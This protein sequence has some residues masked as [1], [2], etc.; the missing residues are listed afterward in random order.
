MTRTE[1]TPIRAPR[2]GPLTSTPTNVITADQRSENRPPLIF[3]STGGFFIYFFFKWCAVEDGNGQKEAQKSCAIV[4]STWKIRTDRESVKVKWLFFDQQLPNSFLFL[5]GVC[6]IYLGSKPDKAD[7]CS[8]SCQKV[9][10]VG[11]F[12]LI[13]VRGLGFKSFTQ[14]GIYL[15][16]SLKFSQRHQRTNSDRSFAVKIG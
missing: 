10:G 8:A 1:S 2:G 15:N 13:Q 4:W 6:H 12:C 9:F 7:R 11:F 3:H 16:L 5:W 14:L